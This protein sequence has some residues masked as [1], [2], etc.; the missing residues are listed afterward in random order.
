VI[1]LAALITIICLMF[2]VLKH[3]GSS[4]WTILKVLAALW[5]ACFLWDAF[6]AHR[7]VYL[8]P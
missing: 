3:I 1:Q 4:I 2:Y 7:V 8:I 6:I 5:A